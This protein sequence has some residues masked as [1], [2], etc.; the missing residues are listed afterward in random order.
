VLFLLDEPEAHLHPR[1]QADAAEALV[2][3]ARLDF[4][5]QLLLAT[6]S[7]EV[8]NRIGQRSEGTLLHIDRQA[9]PS[10]T[11][12]RTDSEVV[13]ALESF[14]DL[15][16]FTS[17]NFLASR[18][19]LFHEGP[20]D[21]AFLQ[22]CARLL[23]ADQADRQRRFFD[24]T[25][26]SLQGVGNAS[27]RG[28]L[29]ALLQPGLFPTLSTG[30]PVRAVL[31]KDRDYSREPRAPAWQALAAHLQSLD[32]VWSRH[33]IESLFLDPP[34]LSAWL[35]P[36]LKI[37]PAALQSLV[38]AA[39]RAANTDQ[40]LEDP[41]VDGRR[42]YHRRPDDKHLMLDENTALQK[43]REE[44]RGSPQ[45]FQPGRERSRVILEALRCALPQ[46]AGLLRGSLLDL[47][48]SV[49]RSQLSVLQRASPAELRSLLDLMT[50][51]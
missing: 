5:I 44:V 43:A 33:S 29:S 3:L 41:A 6:H 45:V 40:R 9:T 2:K 35:E 13:R 14:C 42:A 7:V 48:E 24:Y 19:V 49:E 15:T 1:V 34:C 38:D 30:S 31:L 46:G 8:I 28:V 26:V 25:P 27:A 51:P 23:Y 17:L 37:D 22:A 10:V 20:S 39:V 47:I 18:R 21:Y 12:L 32:V 50:A 11:V 36:S 4:G 16:P